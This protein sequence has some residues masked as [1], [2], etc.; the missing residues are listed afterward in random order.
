M[1]SSR[2]NLMAASLVST[3][4]LGG[5]AAAQTA[6][7]NKADGEWIMITGPI[8]NVTA[9]G[10]QISHDG[11]AVPVEM[12]GYRS[13]STERLRPGDWV[14]VSGRIDDALWERRS[15][16]AASVY[17]SRLQE[18]FWGSPTDNEGDYRGLAMIDLPDE[19]Q[20]IGVTGTVMSVDSAERE[21]TVDVGARNLQVDFTGLTAP[22]LADRGDRVS[23]YGAM[24]DADLWDAREIDATSVVI[25]KQGSM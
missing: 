9:D 10:F 13:T 16:E 2:F 8:S 12:D 21:M 3:I 1:L 18:R 19:G 22:L 15:I 11:G 4:A 23:V 17:S 20:W 25:L 5:A 14:T 24:D 6:P 7:M